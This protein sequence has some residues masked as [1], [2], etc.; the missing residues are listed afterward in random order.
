M[1]T[2]S[3]INQNQCYS[4]SCNDIATVWTAFKNE[5]LF[6]RSEKSAI[7]TVRQTGSIPKL[8]LITR[9]PV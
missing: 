3:N 9:L 7:C 1:A 2:Q 4:M 8:E 5:L 6:H